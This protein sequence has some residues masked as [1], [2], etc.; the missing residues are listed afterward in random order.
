MITK[1]SKHA[2]KPTRPHLNYDPQQPDRIELTYKGE[3]IIVENAYPLGAPQ[4][5]M[6]TEQL[7]QK[8]RGNAGVDADR[9]LQQLANWQSS[10][11]VHPLLNR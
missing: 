3:T 5:P 6:S 2:F 7:Q 9:L 11:N 10:D 4:N 8:F 1:I